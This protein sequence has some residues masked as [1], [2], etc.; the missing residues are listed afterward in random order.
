LKLG[1]EGLEQK[2]FEVAGKGG[3]LGR[4]KPQVQ[5]RLLLA[6]GVKPAEEF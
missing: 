2:V 6:A 4:R 5:Y 3:E 1:Q